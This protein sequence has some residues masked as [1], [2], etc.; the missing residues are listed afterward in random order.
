MYS[1]SNYPAKKNDVYKK[2]SNV[3]QNLKIEL[4]QFVVDAIAKIPKVDA[5]FNPVLPREN[6]EI[7]KN[8]MLPELERYRKEF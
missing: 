8:N 2:D 7:R 3:G 1:L 5:D 6:C 4:D